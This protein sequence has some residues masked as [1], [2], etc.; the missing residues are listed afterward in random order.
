MRDLHMIALFWCSAGFVR[1]DAHDMFPILLGLL[2]QRF[3]LTTYSLALNFFEYAYPIP[4]DTNTIVI[5]MN[6]ATS[7]VVITL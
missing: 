5:G 2:R 1:N 3:A 6:A 7:Q 4:V